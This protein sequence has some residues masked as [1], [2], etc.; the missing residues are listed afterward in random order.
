MANPFLA[1][2]FSGLGA[3][4]TAHGTRAREDEL[5]A[6]ERQQQLED[7]NREILERRQS[8]MRALQLQGAQFGDTQPE[9][10]ERID[11]AGIDQPAFVPRDLTESGRRR[12]IATGLTGVTPVGGR[13]PLTA[14]QARLLSYDPGLAE[15][16]VPRPYSPSTMA[17]A[18]GT[19]A[20]NRVAEADRIVYA[21]NG[22]QAEA[23]RLAIG[24]GSGL[25]AMD[26]QAAV[27]RF[28]R[29]GRGGGVDLTMRTDSAAVP[30]PQAATGATPRPAT[31]A[32]P[33]RRRVQFN[34]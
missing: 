4:L 34:P 6:L 16:F 15:L 2:L 20:R 24:S 9:D 12:A 26:I 31:G 27:T 25:T 19:A 11:F 10:Y 21:A 13:S 8:A 17:S 30:R 3:G 18:E 22:N 33:T 32:A 29:R 7:A 23:L 28:N 1:S 14:S 5:K